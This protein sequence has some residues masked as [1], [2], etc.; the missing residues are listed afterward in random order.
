[1][2]H[3]QLRAGAARDGLLHY[4]VNLA[5]AS[6]PGCDWAGLTSWPVNQQPRTEAASGEIVGQ[7]NDEQYE[8]K[9]GPSLA[10]ILDNAPAALADTGRPGVRWPVFAAAVHAQSPI[11]GLICFG[12]LIAVTLLL[13]TLGQDGG[14][15]ELLS[16]LVTLISVAFGALLSWAS[17]RERRRRLAR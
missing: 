7:I 5:T 3:T 6:V 17:L 9:Q 11:R 13:V 14:L 1:M 4:V 15:P 2:L 10:A 8:T 12:L 16:R